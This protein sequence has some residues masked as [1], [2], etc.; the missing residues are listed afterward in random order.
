LRGARRRG[1]IPALPGTRIDRDLSPDPARHDQRGDVLPATPSVY[2]A[3]QSRSVK[4]RCPSGTSV[5]AQ[6]IAAL[7]GPRRRHS[8]E[9]NLARPGGNVTGISFDAS[10][11]LAG[12]QLQ[13][14]HELVARGRTRGMLLWHSIDGNAFVC[15]AR[16]AGNAMGVQLLAV[17]VHEAGE[18][19]AA[20][21]RLGEPFD[22]GNYRGSAYTWVHRE[23]FAALAAKHRMPAIYGGRDAVV[24]GGLMLY[25]P[26]RAAIYVDKILEGA[27]LA[28]LPVEQPTR[29]EFVVSLKAALALGI[30]IPWSALLRADEVI[31]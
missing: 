4:V 8:D 24:A 13:P 25:E 7:T 22:L 28:D 11:D 14:L 26:R 29:F 31:A 23:R 9:L 30:A 3:P 16:V 6:P 2:M 21:A 1:E 19:D 17:E 27:K 20:F 12:K 18:F 15:A 5:C 10:P